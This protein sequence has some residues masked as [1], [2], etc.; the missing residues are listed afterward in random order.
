[1]YTWEWP[2]NWSFFHAF[3]CA[4]LR[5]AG[6]QHHSETSTYRL[7]SELHWP[8]FHGKYQHIP[9]D[10]PALWILHSRRVRP[11]SVRCQS[12][13]VVWELQSGRGTFLSV[14]H[15]LCA[16]YILTFWHWLPIF[17]VDLHCML[18]CVATSSCH[19][20]VDELATEPF[21]L[22]HHKHGTGY[23]R[24]W[25]CCDWQTRFVVIWKHF[26]FILSTSPGYGLTLWYALGLLV[27]GAIQL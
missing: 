13:Y 21:L 4:S 25:N 8:L 11:R 17:Q 20:H 10:Q 18:Y 1:M 15:N 3:T 14:I 12:G 9:A 16:K 26:C 5:P 6:I 22:L 19:R 7:H 23:R 27:G 24:S 2:W